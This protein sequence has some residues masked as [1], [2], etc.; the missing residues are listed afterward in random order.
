MTNAEKQ[1]IVTAVLESIKASSLSIAQMTNQATVPSGAYIE[2]N[3]SRKLS[4]D[5]L[6]THIVNKAKT[7]AGITS[8]NSTLTSLDGRITTN[9]NNLS[10]L[11]TRVAAIPVQD[12][13]DHIDAT[14]TNPVQNKVIASALSTINAVSDAFITLEWVGNVTC[15]QSSLTIT[16]AD[17]DMCEIVAGHDTALNKDVV[18]V[19]EGNY[20]YC[21]WT[22]QSGDSS[23]DFSKYVKLTSLIAT[24][25]KLYHGIGGVPGLIEFG[26]ETGQ[27]T[28]ISQDDYNEM[29]DT[30]KD[31]RTIWAT[32]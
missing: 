24:N 22:N 2:L 12:V 11:A 1:E 23:F 28:V 7:E 26:G 32:Y 4:L 30:D 14:S 13:D 19:K 3:G 31:E 10:S 21:S 15:Q 29:S 25:E 8:I 17:V 20:C 9:A 5:T 16:E 6:I 18:V 27:I